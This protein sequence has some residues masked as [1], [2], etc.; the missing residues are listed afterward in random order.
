MSDYSSYRDI[1]VTMA[2][3]VATATL[4]RPQT[5][6][7]FDPAL[8]D[9]LEMLFDQLS[10][11][12]SIK[13]I[14]LTGAGRAFSSGGDV[15][16][17]KRRLTDPTAP[18]VR[19]EGAKRLI[20][21]LLNIEQPIISAVNGDAVGLGATVALFCDIVY[22]AETARIGDPHVRVGLVAGDGGAI[23]WPL[24]LGINKA[25]EYLMTGDLI[26]AR[27]A[28]RLGLVNHV[29]PADQVLPAA[30]DMAKR[31]ANGPIRAIKF[32][33]SSV[34]K[35]LRERANLILDTS[36]ALEW[37]TMASLDH[38]EATTAFVEK[39]APVFIGR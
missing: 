37:I 16:E 11:D 19:L 2:D 7:A 5:L 32:T 9:E 26:P 6:N 23:I 35:A 20:L 24:L 39:R 3:G 18:R 14:V 28:E 25:K 34:N 33:K 10:T 12:E 17:M 21:N 8:H 27:E 13:A 22:M 1:K 4:N 38:M 15:K 29:V 30:T 31:L 36:L